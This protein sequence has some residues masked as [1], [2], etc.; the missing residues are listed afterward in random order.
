GRTPGRAPSR[1]R[2]SPAAGGSMSIAIP[3]RRARTAALLLA[4]ALCA[5]ALAASPL[6]LD[7]ALR[8]AEARSPQLA[9]QLAAAQAASAL[10]PAAGKNPAR[11]LFFGVENVPAEGPDRWSLSA[12]PMT[13]KRVGV[14]QQFVRGAKRE[15][16]TAKASA[17]S[18][19]EAALTE[20]QRA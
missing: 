12:D 14:M 17:E 7:E 19:R 3:V 16:R 2:R 1:G 15:D 20:V 11:Q 6:A 10:V 9:A 18:L 13:M 4:G 8:I 5:P